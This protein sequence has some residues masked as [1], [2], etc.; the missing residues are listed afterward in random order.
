MPLASAAA[1]LDSRAAWV[2]LV[3]SPI[4]SIVRAA[5][6]AVNDRLAFV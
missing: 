2:E 6:N 1:A 4:N 3:G 5:V